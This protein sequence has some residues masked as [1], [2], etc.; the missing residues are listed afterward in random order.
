MIR[1]RSMGYRAHD[2]ISDVLG[3]ETHAV[4]YYFEALRLRVLGPYSPHRVGVSRFYMSLKPQIVV[5]FEPDP[6]DGKFH[7][8]EKRKFFLE[9]GIVY[10]AIFLHE[11]L[12]AEDFKARVENEKMAFRVGRQTEQERLGLATNDVLMEDPEIKLFVEREVLARLEALKKIKPHVAGVTRKWAVRRLTA[13][14]LDEVREG[15]TNGRMGHL[16]SRGQSAVIAG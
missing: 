16:F 2:E 11:R 15:I 14:V 4:N 5:D 6:R 1:E 7:L 8:E 3:C 9:K 12:S 10:V 13:E